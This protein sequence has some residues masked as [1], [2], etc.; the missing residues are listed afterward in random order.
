MKPKKNILTVHS[1]EALI[2][3]CNT[4]SRPRAVVEG[5]LN[6]PGNLADKERAIIRRLHLGLKV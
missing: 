6:K 3:T 4:C 2:K 5:A 1:T